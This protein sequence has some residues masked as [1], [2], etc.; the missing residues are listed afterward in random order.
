[1]LEPLSYWYYELYLGLAG[2]GDLLL[3]HLEVAVRAPIHALTLG[4]LGLFTALYA[5]A[6]FAVGG[7]LI[8]TANASANAT[9]ARYMPWAISLLLGGS[10]VGMAALASPDFLARF[11]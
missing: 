2:P 7:W 1:M 4:A 3:R 11:G 9:V 5:G 8:D 10:A 6:L